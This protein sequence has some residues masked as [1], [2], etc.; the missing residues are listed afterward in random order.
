MKTGSV[1]GFSSGVSDDY[2]G[3]LSLRKEVD[4]H[5]AIEMYYYVS[6]N[7]IT[8]FYCDFGFNKLSFYYGHN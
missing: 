8:T 4:H 7:I 2:T 3:I 1:L 6:G 5:K